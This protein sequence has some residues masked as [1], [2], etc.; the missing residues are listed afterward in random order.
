MSRL[1]G[2]GVVAQTGRDRIVIPDLEA[3]SDLSPI[4]ATLKALHG[5]AITALAD[6]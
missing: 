2:L 5:D 3:L 4:A 6:H 1:K